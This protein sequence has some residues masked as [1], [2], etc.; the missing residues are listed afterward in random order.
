MNSYF[1]IFVSTRPRPWPF[2][3]GPFTL[4]SS[5]VFRADSAEILVFQE[6]GGVEPVKLECYASGDQATTT[7]D[8]KGGSRLKRRTSIIEKK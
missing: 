7:V 4:A 2:S 6:G 5:R 1:E 8:F 3:W